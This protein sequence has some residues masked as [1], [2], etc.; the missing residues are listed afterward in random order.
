MEVHHHPSHQHKKKKFQDHF[1]EF[2]MIFLAVTLGFFAESFREHLT[3]G[4]RENQY[5]N[6]LVEDLES[7]QLNLLAQ[8]RIAL[9][10]ISQMDSL[11]VILNN[12]LLIPKN[13]G[14]LYYLARIAP[15]FR[16]L[17]INNRTFEQLKNSGNFRLIK[18]I[19]VSNRIMNYYGKI[20]LIRQVEAIHESEFA[21]FKRIAAKVFDPVIFFQMQTGQSQIKRIAENP[22]L[23]TMDNELLKELSIFAIYMNGSRSGVLDA[24]NDLKKDGAELLEFLK[25]NTILIRNSK[26][27]L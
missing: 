1:L 27:S 16:A 7:D 25:R 15:R 21:D 5:I 2:L 8:A 19:D 17:F 11:T 9:T 22:P 4:K 23:R 12:P 20:Q 6:L 26:D 18:N 13:S 3:E 14:E 10:G 24:E